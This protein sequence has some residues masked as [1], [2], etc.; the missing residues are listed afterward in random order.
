MARTT[1]EALG[2]CCGDVWDG[3]GLDDCIEREEDAC[4]QKI[5]TALDQGTT[6]L[7]EDGFTACL[8]GIEASFQGCPV[9]AGLYRVAECAGAFVGTRPEGDRCGSDIE[10]APGLY[11][12][13]DP[14]GTDVC[15]ALPGD[16][17]YCAGGPCA[18]GLACFEGLCHS[19]LALDSVCDPQH[20]RCGEGLHCT[21]DGACAPLLPDGA[22]CN[23]ARECASQNCPEGT[24]VTGADT[25]N[26]FCYAE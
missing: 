10:C 9:T 18:A 2:G 15:V 21:L 1:C 5:G 16:G 23:S 6:T 20:D 19:P 13:N 14:F 22:T 4:E 7:D 25:P 26:I 3:G 8:A 24:C 17:G 11:C 12:G